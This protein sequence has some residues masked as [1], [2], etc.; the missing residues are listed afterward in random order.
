MNLVERFFGLLTEEALKRGS[1][2]S[3]PQLRDAIIAYVDAHNE[4]AKP[5]KWTKT[6]D[7]ILDKVRRF[8]LRTQRVHAE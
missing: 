7:E 3:I 4:D 5:F 1:H 6:A 8:G 2:T